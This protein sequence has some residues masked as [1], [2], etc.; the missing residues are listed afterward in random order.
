MKRGGT[1]ASEFL[2]GNQKITDLGCARDNK[3][4]ISKEWFE[5]HLPKGKHEL[6]FHFKGNPT[7]LAVVKDDSTVGVI[8]LTWDGNAG[9]IVVNL[10]RDL[11]DGFYAYDFDLDKNNNIPLDIK[12]YGV[13]GQNGYN[14]KTL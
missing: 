5:S 14:C 6:S 3:D 8:T 9:V 1:L 2:T 7:N 11:G 4:A 10:T 12:L 13:C